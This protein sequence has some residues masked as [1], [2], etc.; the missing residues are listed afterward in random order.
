MS[1]KSVV[2]SFISENPSLISDP[3][4][5]AKLIFSKTDGKYSLKK[6]VKEIKSSIANTLSE[7]ESSGGYNKVIISRE[8]IRAKVD[9]EFDGN[10]SAAAREMGLPERTVR[11]WYSNEKSKKKDIKRFVV[12]YGQNDTPVHKGFYQSL[13]VYLKDNNAELIVYKGKY[14]NPT[15]I[16]ESKKEDVDWDYRLKPYLMQTERR[17]NEKITIYPAFTSPT[18]VTPLSGFDTITGNRSGIFPHPKYQMKTVPTPSQSLPKILSTTGAITIPNYSQSKAGTKGEFHHI[19]GA[20]V[21]EIVDDKKFHIRQISADSDGSFYDIAGGEIKK[22]SADGI[23][24]EHRLEALVGG[25]IHV[26][27]ECKESIEATFDQIDRFRPKELFLHDMVD[28]WSVNSHETNNRFLNTAK[29]RH[30]VMEVEKEVDKSVELI[31]RFATSLPDIKVNLVAS[32]H[33]D[34]IDRFLNNADVDKLTVNSEYFHYLSWQKHKSARLVGNGFSF[35]EAYAFSALEK[36]KDKFPKSVGRVEFL[37][38]DVPYMIGDIEYGI[39]GCK[40]SN[41]ARGS[42]LGYSKIGIKTVTAH[43]HSPAIIDGSYT[44]GVLSIINLAYA[45]GQS[46]WLNTNCFTYPNHKRT[47]INIIDGKYCL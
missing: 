26:P 32:N 44:V 16:I 14:R 30:G 34:Q 25:D 10:P 45:S 35:I 4:Q 2:L 5:L 40:G 47:L 36:L 46:S 27:F 7:E 41:G 20:V 42:T 17:L 19:I 29:L 11:R 15:S 1:R 13:Q 28:I 12:T 24:G 8:T 38:R 18:A 31:N 22:Y 33:N 21:V 37:K 3:I 39:H 43:S 9:G 23:S 6:L